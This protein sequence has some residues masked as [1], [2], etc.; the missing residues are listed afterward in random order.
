MANRLGIDDAALVALRAQEEADSLPG[1]YRY[2]NDYLGSLLLIAQ[3]K[4]WADI[5]NQLNSARD[6]I[7]HEFEL[8]DEFHGKL[9]SLLATL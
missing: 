2:L 4:E 3:N 5:K 7:E 9:R 8:T 1:S 6:N